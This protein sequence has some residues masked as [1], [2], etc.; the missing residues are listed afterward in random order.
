ML[1]RIKKI[2]YRSM[3]NKEINYCQA[4]KM[5]TQNQNVILLDVRSKQEYEEGHLSGSVPLCLYD[6]EKQADQVIPNKEQII[7][8]YCSSGSRSKEAQEVL[9]TMGYENVYNLKGGLEEI[10]N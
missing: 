7:I 8:T 2:F 10:N 6:I 4:K 1:E 9:E 3:S 5:L